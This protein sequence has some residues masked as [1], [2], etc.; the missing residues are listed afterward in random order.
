MSRYRLRS[1]PR[2]GGV[3][4]SPAEPR[5]HPPH[6]HLLPAAFHEMCRDEYV[7]LMTWKKA[8]AGE[9]IYNKCPPNASGKG[10]GCPCRPLPRH[11]RCPRLGPGAAP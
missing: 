1:H 5:P 4:G 8:A 3:C 7:M 10:G 9:I 6:P 2:A 11:P